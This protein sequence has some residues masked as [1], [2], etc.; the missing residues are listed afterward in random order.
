MLSRPT[1]T[2]LRRAILG[3]TAVLTIAAG[4]SISSAVRA[5]TFRVDSTADAH[6]E[7]PG[8][9]RCAAAG[10]ACTLRA[11]IEEAS[12]STTP[13]TIVIALPRPSTIQ[14]AYGSL[15]IETAGPL[16]IQ[17]AGPDALTIDARRR[18]RVFSVAAGASVSIA[19]MT[20]TGGATER[21]DSSASDGDGPDGGAVLNRGTLALSRVHVIRNSARRAGGGIWNA[22]ALSIASSRIELNRC[23][24]GD[25]GGVVSVGIARLWRS[26]V[27]RNRAAGFAGGI[28]NSG[29][30]RATETTVAANDAP[31]GGGGLSNRRIATLSRSAV[32]G[33]TSIR[34]AAGIDNVGGLTLLNTTVSGNRGVDDTGGI[35]NTGSLGLYNCTITDNA[36][37]ASGGV[38]SASGSVTIANTIIAGNAAA[39]GIIDPTA[40][41]AVSSPA[42][43]RSVGSNLF[44]EGP[45]CAGGAIGDLSVPAGSVNRLLGPLRANGGSTRTHALLDP[46]VNPAVDAGNP[47]GCACLGTMVTTDQRGRRRPLPPVGIGGLFDVPRCDIGAYEAQPGER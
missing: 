6:D 39:A 45:G 36:A 24:E 32:T 8:D 27:T 46:A 41:C 20:L 17:G 12:A 10:G 9:F 29:T 35:E 34:H 47:L 33:N 5:A 18:S 25:G 31:D 14:L 1:T 11:A 21:D 4:V 16:S 43:L 13:Q 40:D 30:L 37:G 2:S 15:M 7:R 38:S 44:G 19:G 26:S 42:V 23:T 3:L 28:L 22:G